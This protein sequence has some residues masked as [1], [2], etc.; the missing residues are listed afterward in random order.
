LA[1]PSNEAFVREVDEQVRIDAATRFWARWG[2]WLA[3]ALVAALIAVGGYFF[4]SSQQQKTAGVEGET[5]SVALEDLSA[6]D[7][8]KAEPAL[9]GLKSSKVAG[10]RASAQLTLAA[11]A[12][13][14]GDLKGAAAGYAA[15][16]GDTSLAKPY[17]DLALVRQTSAE[18]DTLKPETVV[19][20]LKP[21]AV[22]GNPWFGTAGEMTGIAYVRLGKTREAGA[23]FA[24]LARDE[25]VPESIRSRVVQLAGVL[26]VDVTPVTGKGR[27]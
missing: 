6:S 2:L 11:V 16:A 12:L 7:V 27:I 21:L 25:T 17:R 22:A 5:L 3:V 1:L 19:A 9:K 20:R 8:A 23:L 4:W 14:K 10:Y 24:A 15:I 13:T 26:G 18:Y